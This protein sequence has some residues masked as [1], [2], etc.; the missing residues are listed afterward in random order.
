MVAAVVEEVEGEALVR[1]KPGGSTMGRE[2]IFRDREH[3]ITSCIRITLRKIPP[4]VLLNSV[5]DLE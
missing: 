1:R 2:N 5:G 4:M 3:T